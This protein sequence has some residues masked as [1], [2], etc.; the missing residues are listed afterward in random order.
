MPVPLPAAGAA[1]S[2]FLA[3]LGVL[4]R[5]IS[6]EL[7]DEVIEA[8]GCREKR[9]R[10]LPARA[11]VY[12]VLGLCLFCG[13]DSAGPPGYRSVMRSLTAGLRQL[14]PMAVPT[15]QALTKARQRLGSKPFEL[16]FDAC[17]GTVAGPGTPGAFAFGRRLVA[18]DGTAAELPG[19]AGNTAAFGTAGGGGGPQLRLMALIECGTHAL[20]DAAFD[21]IAR[22]SEQALARRVLHALA[23]GML[24]LADRG[25]PGYQLW[26]LAAATGADLAWRVRNHQVFTIVRRLPDGSFLSVMPTP[27]ENQRLALARARGRAR[28]GPPAGH[29]IRVIEYTVTA[30]TA[31]AT[32]T[33]L[34]RLVTTLLD[35]AEAPAAALAALYRQRWETENGYSELKTR[36]RGTG[37]TFRSRTPDLA[38]QE[39]LAF[40]IVYQ[41]LCALE[42]RAAAHAGIDP[43]KISFTV[44]LR[45][46]RDHA[47]SPPH[48][49]ALARACQHAIADILADLLPDR[50]NRQYQRATRQPKKTFP[51]LKN[52]QPRPPA[53]VTYQITITRN[54]PASGRAP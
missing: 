34:F 10:L 7:V 50:R 25:F 30:R 9:R 24:L 6:P 35:P 28:P 20:I 22:A 13:A 52:N 16:L 31:G 14:H 1:G 43:D 54:P 45:T 44:T 53:T 29:P 47:I 38:C 23:P 3:G 37:F 40:L 36:L 42:A 27:A 12:F 51:Y 19:T 17:R 2:R 49:T 48:P 4:T 5:D 41:A 39:M 18:W 15:R 8:A 32:R 21:G 46:A 11:V 26:G 33:E